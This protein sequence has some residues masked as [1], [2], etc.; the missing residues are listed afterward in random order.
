[1]QAARGYP[2]PNT[3][4]L[5]SGNLIEERSLHSIKIVRCCGDLRCVNSLDSRRAS[6]ARKQQKKAKEQRKGG[7]RKEANFGN[8]LIDARR[9]L[10]PAL[11]NRSVRSRLLDGNEGAIH[12]P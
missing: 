2:L 10:I 9:E 1:M 11:E 12:V 8:L 4:I 6:P 7:D 3:I 5:E